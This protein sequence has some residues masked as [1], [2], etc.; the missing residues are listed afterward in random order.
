MSLIVRQPARFIK[1]VL[2]GFLEGLAYA[3]VGIYM[4][5]KYERESHAKRMVCRNRKWR[6][7]DPPLRPKNSA[8]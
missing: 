3:S 2:F 8:D 5:M 6:E 7:Y 1:R 4:G